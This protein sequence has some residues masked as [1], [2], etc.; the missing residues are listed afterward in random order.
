MTDSLIPGVV[1]TVPTGTI[2]AIPPGA[3]WLMTST[4]SAEY[5]T[6]AVTGP[7]NAIAAT[8]EPGF[9]VNGGWFRQI[10]GGDRLVIIKKVTRL[11]TYAGKVGQLNPYAYYRLG[12]QFGTTMFDSVGSNHLAKGAAATLG[13][14]GP[15]LGDNNFA[16]TMDGTVNSVCFVNGPNPWFGASAL[17]FEAW[18]NNPAFAAGHEQVIC[19]GG[20]GLYM[21]LDAGRLIMSIFLAAQHTNRQLVAMSAAAWHHIAC[22]WGSGDQLRLY[23]DG[24]EVAGDNNT[25]RTGTLDSSPNIY[26]GAFNGTSLFYSGT[27]DECAIYLRKL[28]ADEI[29]RHWSSQSVK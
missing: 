29:K 7:F 12:E 9:M 17:S 27:M 19:L 1:T 22:T 3:H 23:V 25:V 14:T 10:A 11:D 5:A 13:V 26:L 6:A 28:T 20:L 18:I 2:F 15:P 24:A 16:I 21:S 4:A 8:T